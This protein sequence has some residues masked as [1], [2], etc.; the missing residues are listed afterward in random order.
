VLSFKAGS[1]HD[2]V[3]LSFS[4]DAGVLAVGLEWQRTELRAPTT[5]ELLF[6][7]D[8]D[9]GR[10]ALCW[11]GPN[12]RTL[13]VN[14]HSGGI[15]RLD[16]DEARVLPPLPGWVGT[17]STCFTSDG[18]YGVNTRDRYRDPTLACWKRTDD[19]FQSVWTRPVDAT[20]GAAA[21]TLHGFLPDDDHFAYSERRGRYNEGLT[22]V[23]ASRTDP[24]D[25]AEAHFPNQSIGYHGAS[26][27][28]TWLALGAGY[29][30]SIYVFRAD[31][32]AAKPIRLTGKSRK[33][34]TGL[35]FHPSGRFLA[36][37][38]NDETVTFFDTHTFAEA[39]TYMW[40]IGRLRSV[41]FSPDGAL[42]AVGSD[43]GKVVVWDV[44]V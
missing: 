40:K 20:S 41:A 8:N 39:R 2:V 35:A 29:G 12:R 18:R 4:P 30:P 34:Y 10:D 38:S 44:D 16:P 37:T 27:D 36:A 13:F 3:L 7:V 25:V 32:L 43:T 21:R 1:S 14:R 24:A 15:I 17:G 33:H 23:V 28:G 6:A 5:G 26:P 19:G 31:D 9:S 22:L 11:G 42:A